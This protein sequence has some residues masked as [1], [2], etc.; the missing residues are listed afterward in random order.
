MLR[1]QPKSKRSNKQIQEKHQLIKIELEGKKPTNL[2]ETPNKIEQANEPKATV[3]RNHD[4]R[5]SMRKLLKV[6]FSLKT[7]K[8]NKEER[9]DNKS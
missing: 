8:Q 7:Q 4:V 6:S 9:R 5:P 1:K 2:N 3:I